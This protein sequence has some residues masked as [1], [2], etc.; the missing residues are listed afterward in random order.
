MLLDPD[1]A[2]ARQR[3]EE[4]Y[5]VDVRGVIVDN[6]RHLHQFAKE[7]QGPSRSLFEVRIYDASPS[8]PE[9]LFRLSR[10]DNHTVPVRSAVDPL[11]DEN[12]ADTRLIIIS[13]S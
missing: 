1:S 5:P 6:L 9:L 13:A 12:M 10:L 3:A 7:I 2:A 11:F 8:V 4:I